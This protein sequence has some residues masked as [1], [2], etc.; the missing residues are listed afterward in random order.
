VSAI[1]RLSPKLMAMLDLA[2]PLKLAELRIQVRGVGRDRKIEQAAA[3]SPLALVPF[4][5]AAIRVGPRIGGNRSAGIGD[6]PIHEVVAG[7]WA[8]CCCRRRDHAELAHRDHQAVGGLRA[9]EL[10]DAGVDLLGLRREIDGLL[11]NMRGNRT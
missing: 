1:L 11:T 3:K 5:R 6:R 4:D 10:V 2:I 8:Y 7:S 9:A